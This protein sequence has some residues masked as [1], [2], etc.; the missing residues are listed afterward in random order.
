MLNRRASMLLTGM[1]ALLLPALVAKDQTGF[2]GKWKLDSKKSQSIGQAP[3]GLTEE[4]KMDGT[5]V[6]IRSKYMEPKNAIYPISM[7]G[8]MTNEIK[9][10]ADGSDVTNSIGPFSHTSKT[11]LEG[12]KMTTEWAAQVEQGKVTGKW[13][14]TL[15][16]DGKQMTVE[17]HTEE[18]GGKVTDSNLLFV[19]K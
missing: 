13:V 3:D 17:V 1:L 2:E 7:L 8:L 5:Q 16:A 18:P 10:N 9:L 14:R 6:V 11:T 15:S 19:R 12:N 4:I